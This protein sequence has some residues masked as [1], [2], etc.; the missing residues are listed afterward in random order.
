MSD[1]L[2]FTF[3]QFSKRFP[4]LEC[5]IFIIYE[6]AQEKY[7]GT[8]AAIILP[9]G[10][11]FVGVTLCSPMDKFIRAVGRE[12]AIGRAYQAYRSAENIFVQFDFEPEIYVPRSAQD[13]K[14][15]K[16]LRAYLE[17]AIVEKKRLVYEGHH[18][19]ITSHGTLGSRGK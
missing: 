12:K 4:A 14:L 11:A 18:D 3:H 8:E 2:R 1:T 5:A 15:I 7:R 13:A 6:S 19:R 9:S 10:C 17:Q 16:G